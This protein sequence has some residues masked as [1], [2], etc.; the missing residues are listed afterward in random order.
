MK[1]F[2]Y[3][4]KGTDLYAV[5]KDGEK[6]LGDFASLDILKYAAKEFLDPEDYNDVLSAIDDHIKSIK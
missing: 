6:I 5:M 3:R 1:T 4:P 2:I